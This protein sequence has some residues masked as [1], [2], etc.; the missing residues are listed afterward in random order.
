VKKSR[1]HLFISRLVRAFPLGVQILLYLIVT[2]VFL[3][4]GVF[5]GV[6][7]LIIVLGLCFFLR[8]KVW[9][10]IFFL[11]IS[12]F[13]FQ[14]KIE[15]KISISE[16]YNKEV[17]VEGWII[18]YPRVSDSINIE[19]KVKIE[20]IDLNIVDSSIILMLE[21]TIQDE[22][23]RMFDE[24]I[25]VGIIREEKLFEKN[26]F[27]SE[28]LVGKIICDKVEVIPEQSINPKVLSIV[29]YKDH[30]VQIV[31]AK[32]NQP[33]SDLFLG[34][35]FGDDSQISTHLNNDI[36]NSGTAHIIAA[37]G[38]NINL[39]VS[40]AFVFGKKFKR[41]RLVI[42]SDLFL[43]IYLLLVGI[44][45]VPAKRAIIMQ[46]YLTTAWIFG[47]KANIFYGFAISMAFLFLE[48]IYVY[49][50]LSFLLSFIATFGI[51]IFYKP[52]RDILNKIIK[53]KWLSE[54]IAIT[55]VSTMATA[56]VLVIF[57]G[58]VNAL[59]VFTNVLISPLIPLI[60]YFGFVFLILTSLGIHSLFLNFIIYCMLDILIK[61]ID[62]LGGVGI[63]TQSLEINSYV[64]LL[65]LVLIMFGWFIKIFRSKYYG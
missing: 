31:K 53:D 24:I 40:L 56:P 28:G 1:L 44:D 17:T 58:K 46:I 6:F 3:E 65:I 14:Q 32:L 57:F 45:N 34:M 23:Y 37:S 19:A 63:A 47:K 49:K 22:G 38:Y 30:L 5:G 59:S 26:Y 12:F 39:V 9:V 54:A 33:Y 43:M 27:A 25:C 36:R 13:Q 11:L 16:F 48:N 10:L 64:I 55:T 18:N 52:L 51:I 62:I 7:C 41:G 42:F 60:F 61:V 50:S 2:I 35:I 8:L 20:K 4:N 21:S 29:Y 15:D